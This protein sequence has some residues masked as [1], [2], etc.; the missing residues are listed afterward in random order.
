[1]SKK[2]IIIVSVLGTLVVCLALALAI[3]L[4]AEQPEAQKSTA[5]IS[6]IAPI[7]PTVAPTAT[8][9][10]TKA[11]TPV[12]PTNTPTPIDTGFL[13]STAELKSQHADMEWEYDGENWMGSRQFASGQGIYAITFG[14]TDDN[15]TLICYGAILNL[16]ASDAD[17]Q[18]VGDWGANGM[19]EILPPDT[20][21]AAMDFFLLQ[22]SSIGLQPQLTEIE[23]ID[24]YYIAYS[25]KYNSS[26]DTVRHMFCAAK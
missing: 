22:L 24:G 20:A 1:M 11:P 14:Q 9:A 25:Y 10:P 21:S 13:V 26:Q 12:P 8:T 16:G 2:S 23:V 18:F 19:L 3:V 6:T 5:K 4:S 15:E 17:Y 7:K